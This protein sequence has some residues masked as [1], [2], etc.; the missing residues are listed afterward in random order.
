MTGLIIG[1]GNRYRGDDGVGCVVA[2]KLRGLVPSSVQVV[3]HDGE[4][5]GLVSLWQA[6]QWCIV[7]DAVQGD[8]TDAMEAG[9]MIVFDRCYEQLPRGFGG[10]SSHGCGVREASAIGQAIGR[11]PSH[12]VVVGIVGSCFDGGTVMTD[13]V[14][15]AIDGTVLAVMRMVATLENPTLSHHRPNTMGE[16]RQ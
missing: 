14:R 4:P 12:L 8:V 6:A 2:E 3:E 10:C 9:R 13:P 11:V 16:R 5:L 1:V 7:I 15:D